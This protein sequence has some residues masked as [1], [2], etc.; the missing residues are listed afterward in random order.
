V[1]G[2]CKQHHRV[3]RKIL[4]KKSVCLNNPTETVYPL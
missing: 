2:G 3:L 1:G 4:G